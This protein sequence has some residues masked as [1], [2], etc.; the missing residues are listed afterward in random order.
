MPKRLTELLSEVLAKSQTEEGRREL[1]AERDRLEAEALQEAAQREKRPPEAPREAGKTAQEPPD[2]V[3]ELPAV[4]PE[5]RVDPILPVVQSVREAPEREAGRLAFG[6]IIDPRQDIPEAAQLPLLPAPEGPRVPLLELVDRNG[7][8]TM[9]QGRGAPLDLA[10]YIGACILT[11]HRVRASR[12]R[13]VTTVRELRDFL[14]GP[15]W[16]PGPTGNRPGDWQRVREAAL[17][18][19]D[20]WLPLENGNLW[21]AVAVREIPPADYRPE[22]LDRQV[23]F[24]MG[25]ARRCGPWPGDRPAGAGAVAAGVGAEVSGLHRDAFRRLAGGR[26]PPTPPPQ[27]ERPPVEL[28]SG[29]LPDPHG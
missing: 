24:D 2:G 29:E 6:G 15:T 16:R 3:Q 27:P 18:A 20:L 5:R 17:N 8:P 19:S 10:V 12:G 7:V 1:L 13:L 9:A 25:V 28:R 22:Y 26:H 21:R 23:I 4:R 11:P 14:F